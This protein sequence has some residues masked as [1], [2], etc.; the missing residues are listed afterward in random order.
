MKHLHR[1]TNERTHTYTACKHHAMPCALFC[2]M[3]LTHNCV[4]QIFLYDKFK[5]YG[6]EYRWWPSDLASAKHR[7]QKSQI[8]ITSPTPQLTL[9]LPGWWEWSSGYQSRWCV[10]W[11]SLADAEEAYQHH[12]SNLLC[13][14]YCTLERQAL[15][16]TKAFPCFFVFG[17]VQALVQE[18]RRKLQIRQNGSYYKVQTL[19]VWWWSCRGCESDVC[20]IGHSCAWV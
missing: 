3:H 20:F 4:G 12:T 19:R 17:H 5:S 13:P 11:A 9:T 1:Y 6:L 10:D 18:H 8:C 14:D 15:K 2:V 7:N 16:E